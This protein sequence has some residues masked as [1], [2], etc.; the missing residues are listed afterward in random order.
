VSN[1]GGRI[2]SKQPE[3]GA[4]GVEER[5]YADL[6]KQLDINPKLLREELPKFAE[7]LKNAPDATIYERANAAYVVKDYS[8]AERL[9]CKLPKKRRR[10]TH[11]RSR[12]R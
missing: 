8:E 1:G 5:T 2:R 9:A 4:A 12:R 6:A 10:K 11:L 3:Q 7:K